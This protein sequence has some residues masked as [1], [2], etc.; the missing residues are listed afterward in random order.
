M[1]GMCL[2]LK[3]C[4]NEKQSMVKH[5]LVKSTEVCVVTMAHITIA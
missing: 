4:P 1:R 3:Y 2:D 5:P